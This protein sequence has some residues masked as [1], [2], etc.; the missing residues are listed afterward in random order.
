MK[1]VASCRGG[2][3]WGGSPGGA[4]L[5]QGGAQRGAAPAGPTREALRSGSESPQRDSSPGGDG[6][7]GAE[8]EEYEEEEERA[9]PHGGSS[10]GSAWRPRL[11]AR[12]SAR[13]GSRGP[14]VARVRG[15]GEG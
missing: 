6:A 10:R 13:H 4:S 7:R 2:G 12:L 11:S 1:L 14:R 5:P 8:Y 9:R 15:E 3:G